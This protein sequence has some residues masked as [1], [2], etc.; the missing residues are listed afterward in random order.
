VKKLFLLSLITLF[1]LPV[2]IYAASI[3]EAET[4]GKG[5]LGIG[6][7]ESIVFNKDLKFKSAS[8]LGANQTIKNPEIDKAYQT[9]FKVSYGLLDNLDI[10]VN[11]GASD[12]KVKADSYDGSSKNA[13]E[14]INSDTSF[15]Y[16]LGL[17]TTRE[18]GNDWLLGC[19]LQYSRSKNEADVTET[20]VGGDSS[21]T[22]YKSA[23]VQEWHVAPYIARRIN[24]FTPYFGV[25]Y[26]D[27]K[28]SMKNSSEAGWTDNHKY[29]ADDNVGFFAGTD[30]KI[31]ENWKLNLEGRFIDETAMN[32][33]A[34][35]KF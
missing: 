28:L 6:A 29:E 11:L 18:L 13:D 20:E 14:K 17:K 27:M 34:T 7:N 1:C 2:T 8:G 25:R 16:G 23:V 26:S 21:S 15:A 32:V 19:D 22:K 31:G 24:D 10:Y 12:Y 35:Y 33:G 9:M 4:Q 3:G 30:Y 5:K